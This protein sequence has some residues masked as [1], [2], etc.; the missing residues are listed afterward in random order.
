MGFYFYVVYEVDMKFGRRDK[1]LGVYGVFLFFFFV[2]VGFMVVVVVLVR[3]MVMDVVGE[4]GFEFCIGIVFFVIVVEVYIRV[5]RNI[6][7]KKN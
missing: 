7:K 5:F 3:E 4:V 2:V 1:S 6:F